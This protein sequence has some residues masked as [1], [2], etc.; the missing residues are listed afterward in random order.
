MDLLYGTG[1]MLNMAQRPGH[2][3]KAGKDTKKGRARE[4]GETATFTFELPP[5]LNQRFEERAK[6]E[7]RT[8]KSVLIRALER[9]L[10]TPLSDS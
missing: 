2:K 7:D 1:I 9:Y 5:E 4:K 10:A 6:A 8:K 3:R